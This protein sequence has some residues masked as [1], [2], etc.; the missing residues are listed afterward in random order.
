M[1]HIQS[2]PPIDADA[3]IND[4]RIEPPRTLWPQTYS[5]LTAT[6][7]GLIM[8][9]CIGWSGPVLHLLSISG[10]LSV[11]QTQS[12]F[13]AS[14]MP[15]GALF[16]GL[17]GGMLM[18]KFGRKGTMM[19]NSV[20]FALTFLCLAAAQ[21]VW[22]LFIGRFLGGMASGITTIACPTY[23]SEVASANV[24]GTLGSSFQLM[25]TIGV[26][27]PGIIG[28]ISTWR[29]I[30]VAC[31]V[32]CLVWAVLL[33]FCPETPAHLLA[34]KNFDG[35]R[36]SL[37][38]LRGHELIETELAEAQ[39]TIEDAANKEFRIGQLKNPSN[40]KPL[41]IAMILM[42]GQQL[43]GCNAVLFFS[44][45]I[46][47][48]AHTSLDSFVENIILSSVQVFATALSVAIIDKLGRRILL[49]VSAL[50][51]IISLYGLGLY[52]YYLKHNPTLAAKISFLPLFSVCLFI[53]AFSIGFGPIPWLMMSELFSP[54]AKG[55]AS[56]ITSATNWTL[57][58]FVTQFFGP[59]KNIIGTAATFWSFATVLVLVMAFSIFQLPET[60]GKTLEEIQNY[61]RGPEEDERSILDNDSIA[62]NIEVE[63][64]TELH[65]SNTRSRE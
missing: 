49:I 38:F 37:Q 60:K 55:I 17:S 31:I 5:A 2:Y 56:S 59:I 26:L 50:V 3:Q 65:I 25:V 4:S 58:F 9:T 64:N 30:S 28:A 45:S 20:F 48:A 35:A 7:G 1:S 36:Q 10:D 13:I 52:F 24:R 32:W 42:L 53:F 51:M 8:G 29:W 62:A 63:I 12:N 44:V 43:S 18:N 57:A 46:F 23:V 54:E 39:S 61:F 19:G 11:T 40:R 22:M 33:L 15:A 41:L 27:Y 14:L 6:I 21:N 34:Q 16:G 47:E